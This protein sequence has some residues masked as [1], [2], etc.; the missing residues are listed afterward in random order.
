MSC[1]GFEP[2][3]TRKFADKVASAGYFVVMPDFF[4]GDPYD[5]ATARDTWTVKHRTLD[6]VL[7]AKQVI[8]LLYKKGFSSVGAVGF[9]WGGNLVVKLAKEKSLK[10]VVAAHPS[11]VTVEEIQEVKTPIEILGAELDTIAPP[12]LIRQFEDILESKPKIKSFV[13]IYPGVAHGWTIRYNPDNPE[14]VAAAEEAQRK[15]IEWLDKFLLYKK[16]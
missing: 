14:E 1:Q 15:M 16:T 10:A 9:C 6:S 11:Y 2:P 7:G 3:L 5:P 13:K 4:N 12:A 8:E